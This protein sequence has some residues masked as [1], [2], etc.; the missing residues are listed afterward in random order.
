MMETGSAFFLDLRHLNTNISTDSDNNSWVDLRDTYQDDNSLSTHDHLHNAILGVSLGL[1]S[2]LTIL[3]NLLVLYAVK[4]EKSLHTVG[5]LYI[6]SLSMADLIVGT[7]VMPLNLVYLLEHQWKLGRAACQFW[8]ITD[9][10]ASTASIFSIFILCLDRYRSVR[11]PLKY[12]RYRTKGRASTMI[13]G[14][15]LLSLMWI[16]PILGWRLF[17]HVDVKPEAENKCDTDFRFV[18]WFKVIAAIFNFYVPSV[19]MLWF[20]THIYLAVRRHLRE[21]ERIIRP[22]VSFGENENGQN[23]AGLRQDDN[24]KSPKKETKANV[25]YFKKNHLLEQNTFDPTYSLENTDKSQNSQS[26]SEKEAGSKCQQTLLLAIMTKWLTM[27]RKD[28]GRSP[29]PEQQQPTAELP[30]SHSPAFHDL[31][32]SKGVNEHKLYGSASECSITGPDLGSGAYNTGQ[33][34]GRQSY[35]RVLYNNSDFSQ[36]LT[37]VEEAGEENKLD[38]DNGVTLKESWYTFVDK[39]CQRMQSS[40]IRKERKAAKQLGFIIAAFLLCWIPYFIAFMVMAFCRECVHHNLHMFTIWLGYV[41][42]TLNP[43]IYPL[44]NG[45]FKKV[46]RNILHMPGS[47]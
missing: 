1:L 41:N 38:A 7:A 6:V 11:Q 45:N 46:F 28:C 17:T 29:S 8:L 43:F 19:L 16:V 42:S 13:C 10:V 30:L 40:R 34:S 18:T 23:T 31:I 14:A 32:C 4:T 22:T 5:N 9:Y 36:S 37:G 35:T 20:Y 15:W 44:C 26:R 33:L 3:M 21:K 2:L 25:E 12:L 47:N 24:R 27:A 39:F